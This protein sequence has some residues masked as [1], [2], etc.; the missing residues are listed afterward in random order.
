MTPINF[1]QQFNTT[2]FTMNLLNSIRPTSDFYSMG[3]GS[4]SIFGDAFGAN[5]GMMS[6]PFAM[7][8]MSMSSMPMMSMPMFQ[9]PAFNFNFSSLDNFF[10]AYSLFMASFLSSN[11]SKYTIS[12]GSLALVYLAPLPLL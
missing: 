1:G 4:T 11:S 6:N 8:S 3:L 5:F 10:I 7:A 9:M 2:L 12:T